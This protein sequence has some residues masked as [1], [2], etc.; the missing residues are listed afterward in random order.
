MATDVERTQPLAG[1]PEEKLDRIRR[2][3][4]IGGMSVGDRE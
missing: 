4:Q 3:V 2:Q 1:I